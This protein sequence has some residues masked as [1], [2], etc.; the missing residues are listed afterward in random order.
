M[1]HKDMTHV[2]TDATP[3][4]KDTTPVY[5]EMSLNTSAEIVD[6]DEEKETPAC[7]LQRLARA[8]VNLNVAEAQANLTN[9]NV[10]NFAPGAKKTKKTST[11]K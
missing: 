5:R 9:K 11:N 3:V 1:R 7:Q 8:F 2:Y 10:T 6:T 4:H